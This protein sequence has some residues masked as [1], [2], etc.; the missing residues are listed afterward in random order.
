MPNMGMHSRSGS[1]QYYNQWTT[2]QSRL[3]DEIYTAITAAASYSEDMQKHVY[4]LHNNG[5]I[6]ILISNIFI[7]VPYVYAVI[8]I[9]IFMCIVCMSLNLFNTR[10]YVD[11]LEVWGIGVYPLAA[12]T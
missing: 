8:R 6:C 11:E 4:I 9:Y 3:S 2:T 7:S 1:N 12:C 5:Q 10:M